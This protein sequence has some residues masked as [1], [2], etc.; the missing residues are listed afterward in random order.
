MLY[1]RHEYHYCLVCVC[2]CV[3]GWGVKDT[4]IDL[5]YVYMALESTMEELNSVRCNH[6]KLII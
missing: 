4:E 3:C 2:V 6:Q 5:L 1:M